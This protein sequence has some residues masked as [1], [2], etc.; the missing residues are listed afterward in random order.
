M[1]VFKGLQRKSLSA[2]STEV[3]RVP[4]PTQGP[5]HRR[6]PHTPLCLG[7][8]YKRSSIKTISRIMYEEAAAAAGGGAQDRGWGGAGRLTSDPADRL[9]PSFQQPPL[10][11]LFTSLNER[12]AGVEK[13]SRRQ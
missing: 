12:G 9:I 10:S 6:V 7:R 11:L 1:P 5:D 4:A 3:R 13:K 2:N 8:C